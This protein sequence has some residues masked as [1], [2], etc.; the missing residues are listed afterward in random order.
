[1][2]DHKQEAI[3]EVKGIRASYKYHTLVG[4]KEVYQETEVVHGV[5]VSILKGEIVAILGANGAGKSTFM[6]AIMGLLDREP[7]NGRFIGEIIFNGH[8][9]NGLPTERI[10]KLGI[11]LVPEG[12][13]LFPSLTV[14]DNLELG[15]YAIRGELD[16]Q[17]KER[18]LAT[19][20]RLF[21][22]LKKRQK[23]LADRLSGGEAQMVAVARGIL[24]QPQLLLLDEPCLG[25]AP[26]LVRELMGSLSTLKREFGI[27]ILMAEQN[28]LAALSIA[29]HGYLFK[30]GELVAEGPGHVLLASES[31]KMAY[32]GQ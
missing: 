9:I 30:M 29:D 6:L 28:A 26:L 4:G 24:S 25:L 2:S 1:M 3:L 20:F 8:V 13:L 18:N 21:P 23:Q 19:I 32:L 27:S 31:I 15:T 17:T 16:K 7:F 12:K 22:T 11:S 5:D 14:L 10:V